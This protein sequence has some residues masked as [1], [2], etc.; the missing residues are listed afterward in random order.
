MSHDGPDPR[1][2]TAAIVEE[3]E[4]IQND[5]TRDGGHRDEEHGPEVRPERASGPT[6]VFEGSR[7]APLELPIRE[8]IVFERSR[9]APLELPIREAI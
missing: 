9:R 8:A 1:P 4:H 2:G 6:F 3:V 7:R 5:E